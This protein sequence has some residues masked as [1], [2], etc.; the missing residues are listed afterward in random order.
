MRKR[1][2]GYI[3]LSALM[4]SALMSG[5]GQQSA[6]SSDGSNVSAKSTE[7]R[8]EDGN[9]AENGNNSDDKSADGS[10]SSESDS[11]VS[12]GNGTPSENGNGTDDSSANGTTS[13]E[14][15]S[16]GTSSTAG[17]NDEEQFTDR[18]LDSSYDESKAETITLT[19]D[20]AKSSSSS[21]KID[22]STVTIKSEGIYVL[23]GTL[24]D[25]QIIVDVNDSDKVQLVLNGV[26]IT[27]SNSACI[28]VKTADKTF[29][30]LAE[31]SENKLQDTGA[32]YA[33]DGDEKVDGVIYSKD[34]ITFNGSGTLNITA[35]YSHGIVGNDDVKFTDGTINISA[36]AKGVKANDSIRVKDGNFNIV[37]EDD[38]LH[39]SNNEEEGKG[40]IYIAGGTFELSSGDDGVHAEKAL[41]INGGTI[42][43]AKS[44]EGIEG[45]TIEING[46]DIDVAASDD[47][48]NATGT[49]QTATG[50]MGSMDDVDMDF[51]GRNGGGGMMEAVEDAVL[52]INGGDIYVNSE[53]DGIDSNGYLYVNG[54]IIA[55]DGPTNDGN[56]ALDTGYEAVLS[57][58]E[59]VAVGS[60]GMAETF[61]AESKEYSILYNFS[62]TLPAGTE[63]QLLDSSGNVVCKYDTKKNANSVVFGSSMIVD[64]E[65]TIKAGN[66]ED[67]I[68]VS[69]VSTSAGSAGGFGGFK[70]FDRDNSTD[71]F[72]MDNPQ[73]GFNM[74][75]GFPGG[76]RRGKHPD[77]IQ[78]DGEE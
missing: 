57:G 30:T 24:N 36:K 61:S 6:S 41:V 22:G 32:A 33:T 26:D 11:N 31:G 65:Y 34:D 16:S 3:I 1:G 52:T 8:S 5:C 25:G 58:G 75:N 66:T 45:A 55:V 40:Y 2:Y 23:S 76:G 46:G 39:T 73:D 28:Y 7:S 44:K 15:A 62:E 67:N 64:G 54:G 77:M 49:S 78:Q 27:C 19:G 48:M 29:V 68:T 51:G 71:G 37:S 42:D 21:V 17:M 4:M 60:S 47:G 9:V 70:G 53:G 56:G 13:N 35:G 38:A 50:K 18:D 63:I 43:V 74:D 69:G 14:E 59:I 10:T 12:S 20:S 72:E